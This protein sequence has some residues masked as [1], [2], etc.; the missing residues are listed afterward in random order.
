MSQYVLDRLAQELGPELI[1]THAQ[2]GDETALVTPQALRRS[3]LLLRDDPALAMDM[4]VDITAVDHPQEAQRFEVVYHFHSL[5]HGHRVRLKVRPDSAEE[6]ILD[7]LTDLWKGADWLERETFDMF[8]IRFAGH[9]DLRRLL[10][11]P[12]FQGHPLR[13]DYPIDGEQPRIPERAGYPEC[14]YDA[15]EDS[16][17]RAKGLQRALSPR[18][19]PGVAATNGSRATHDEDGY[20]VPRQSFFLD[21]GPSHP[22]MHGTIRISVELEGEKIIGC[23]ADIGFLHRGFEKM[24]ENRT[25]NQAIVYTDRLNYVSPLINNVGWAMTIEKLLGVEVPERCQALRVLASEISRVADHLTCVAASTMEVGA[26]TAFLYL[27]EGREELYKLIERLCG[28]R[29]TTTYTRIGG[30]AADLPDGFA[31]AMQAAFAKTRE[32]MSDVVKLLNGNRIFQDRMVGVGAISAADAISYGITGPFLRSTGVSYDVRKAA[33]YCGYEQYEFEVPVGSNGDNWDRYLV[34]MEEMRQAMRIAEQVMA[35]LP[36]GPI[37]V[38]D[39]SIV[40]PPKS[41]VYTTIEGAMNHFKLTMAGHG[42]SPPPGEA[43]GY[44]E[45]GNG[46]LGFY[47]VT[48]GSDIAYRAHCRPPCLAPMSALPSILTGETVADVIATFGTVNMIGGELDR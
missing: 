45:G 33:P 38:A 32:M 44:V 8:G 9:P 42:V 20:P 15:E 43:Y 25:F 6:P 12:E 28:G 11:Y 16:E 22:A 13:K 41:E 3:A 30:V 23:D 2:H 39:R 5:H 19:G 7:S 18:V 14:D 1:G 10:L 26:F 36:G 29:V 40:P 48:D 37:R 31:E 46:E 24:C 47:V 27:I 4:L 17:R 34:R 21:M 35:T